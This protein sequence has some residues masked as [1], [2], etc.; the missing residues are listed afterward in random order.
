MLGAMYSDLRD[1]AAHQAG[2]QDAPQTVSDC[3]AEPSFK[4]LC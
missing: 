3:D 1:G 2:E 4:G